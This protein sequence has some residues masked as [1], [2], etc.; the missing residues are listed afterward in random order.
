MATILSTS[1]GSLVFANP[2]SKSERVHGAIRR[3]DNDGQSW[4]YSWEV[5]SESGAFAYSCLTHVAD[6]TQVGLLWETSADGCSGPSCQMVFS[7]HTVL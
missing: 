6:P 1:N 7:K 5:T 2:A 4:P 3:S